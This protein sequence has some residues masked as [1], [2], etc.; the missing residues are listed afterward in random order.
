MDGVG[1]SGNIPR[2]AEMGNV[3]PELLSEETIART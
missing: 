2:E 3:N 1:G